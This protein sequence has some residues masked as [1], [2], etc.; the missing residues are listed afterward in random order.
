VHGIVH[1]LVGLGWH[2][3]S[4]L[5]FDGGFGLFRAIVKPVS[6]IACNSLCLL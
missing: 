1:I 2:F 4:R 5:I 6:L 3:F